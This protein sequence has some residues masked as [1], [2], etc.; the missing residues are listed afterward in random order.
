MELVYLRLEEYK[1]IH[2][3][4]FNFSLGLSK[5]IKDISVELGL[6]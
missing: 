1:N 5:L 4:G 2:S 6:V 3:Q